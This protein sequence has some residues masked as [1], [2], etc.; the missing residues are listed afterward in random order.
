MSNQENPTLRKSDIVYHT[1]IHP[2]LGIYD[3]DELVIRTVAE[4]FF[5]G[6]EKKEKR[7]FLFPYSS[8]NKTVFVKR[9][10]ALNKIKEAEA[11]KPNIKLSTET[12]YEEY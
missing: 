10:D 12:Y 4:E 9:Q 7:A 3:L 11:N 6:I 5:V 1:R 2:S 8:I